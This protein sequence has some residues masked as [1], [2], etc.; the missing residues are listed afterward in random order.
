[1]QHTTSQGQDENPNLPE[2]QD[3]EA[4]RAAL[5]QQINSLELRLAQAE[6]ELA[7]TRSGSSRVDA[8]AGLL[9]AATCL[10]AI[11][12]PAL[13][14]LDRWLLNQRGLELFQTWW[15][16]ANPLCYS[17]Y[18]SY[19]LVIFPCLLLCMPLVWALMRRLRTTLARSHC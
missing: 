9:L 7:A 6:A 19:F 11:I 8:K 2:P 14:F 17:A 13:V 3:S 12:P 16:R 4:E 1:M 15:C 10:L 18:P 5:S